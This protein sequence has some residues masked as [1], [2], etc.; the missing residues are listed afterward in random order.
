VE[1]GGG[2]CAGEVQHLLL[3]PVL[4]RPHTQDLPGEETQL[5][6]CPGTQPRLQ[7]YSMYSSSS[8]IEYH[9]LAT[10]DE[11]DSSLSRLFD[12]TF[13]SQL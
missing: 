1:G 10:Q 2:V 12:I 13:S 9:V 8:F 6:P 4:P 5:P 11:D 3:R 7:R